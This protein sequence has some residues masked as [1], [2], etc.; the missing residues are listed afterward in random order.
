M[1]NN[2]LFDLKILDFFK[3]IPDFISYICSMDTLIQ[4]DRKLPVWK[5]IIGFA[6]IFMSI[7]F[8]IEG[9]IFT[10]LWLLMLSFVLM[11]TDGSEID[12]QSKK[13]RKTHSFLGLKVGQWKTL[14]DPMYVS[15]FLTKE[16]VSV[17]ALSAETTNSKDIIMLNLFYNKNKHFTI[18]H[19]NNLNDAFDVASHIADALI[20]DILDATEKGNFQ[21]VDKDILRDKGEIVYTN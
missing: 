3:T 8:F 19:T 15:I 10:G 14:I 2:N 7:Y 13:Y 18:Y 16:D 4:Y 6:F 11:R 5:V 21:W 9:T 20:I 17:R 1:F 12:L